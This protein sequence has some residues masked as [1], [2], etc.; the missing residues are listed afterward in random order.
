MRSR[1]ASPKASARV[2]VDMIRA[3]GA[4]GVSILWIEHIVHALLAV[5]TRLVVLNFGQ[6]VAEGEPRAV[7]ASQAVREIYLG[8]LE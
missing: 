4:S 8:A 3:I 7:M 6:V 2:L 1:A 5:V